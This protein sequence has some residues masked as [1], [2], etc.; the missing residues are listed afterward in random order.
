VEVGG[1]MAVVEE[2]DRPVVEKEVVNR[3]QLALVEK[4]LD[5]KYGTA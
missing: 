1:P 3:I 4:G 5:R 2:K